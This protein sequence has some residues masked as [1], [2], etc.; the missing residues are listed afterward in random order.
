VAEELGAQY[1][2][3]VQRDDPAKLVAGLGDGFGADLV[4]DCTGVSGAL[5]Q[6]LQLVRPNGRVTKIGWGPQ[7]LD[8]SLDPLV[9]KAVTLQGS[10]SHTFP[11]WERVL[12]LL[13]TGQV[14][15]DPV[16]GGVYPLAE[17]GEAFH[18]MESGANVKSVLRLSE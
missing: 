9:Q 4:V 13:A 2:V 8:Y 17:W 10:F 3:N 11:T 12:T 7:P 15:L 18:Q 6:A 1:T 14:N 16:I 5:Q